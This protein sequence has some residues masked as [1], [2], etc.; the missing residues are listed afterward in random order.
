MSSR[1]LREAAV[2]GVNVVNTGHVEY[3]TVAWMMGVLTAGL[4]NVTFAYDSLSNMRRQANTVSSI[5][6]G[7]Q[8]LMLFNQQQ[9]DDRSFYLHA[10]NRVYSVI[11]FSWYV[12]EVL[13]FAGVERSTTIAVMMVMNVANISLLMSIGVL[14]LRRVSQLPYVGRSLTAVLISRGLNRRC[15]RKSH[16]SSLPVSESSSEESFSDVDSEEAE[17]GD[18]SD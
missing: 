8:L 14:G 5:L 9:E 6:V 15:F 2:L 16:S 13:I 12:E 11:F 1:A 10:A 3:S 17:R 7:V 4:F 18:L